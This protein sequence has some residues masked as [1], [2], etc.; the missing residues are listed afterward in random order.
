MP[1][2]SNDSDRLLPVHW[3]VKSSESFSVGLKITGLDYK[4]WLKDVSECISKE[5]INIS[6]VDIKAIDTIAE[7]N[8]IVQVK[9]NRQLNRLMRKLL[10]LKILTMLKE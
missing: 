7:A 9:N 2:L 3:N 8:I 1:I 10:N 6:S 5:N 4:G